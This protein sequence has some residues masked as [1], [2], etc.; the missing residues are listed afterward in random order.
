[1]NQE[2]TVKKRIIAIRLADKIRR[3]PEYANRIGLK[4]ENDRNN[5]IESQADKDMADKHGFS[6]I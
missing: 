4:I 3:N 1:M 5:R 6:F 2:L